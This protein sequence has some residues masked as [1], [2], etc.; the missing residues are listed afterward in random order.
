MPDITYPSL[1]DTTE[2][3]ESYLPRALPWDTIP[4]ADYAIDRQ[5]S[6][7]LPQLS[8]RHQERATNDPDFT[9]TLARVELDRGMKEREYLPL[10]ETMR[11]EQ[12]DAFDNTLLELENQRR[13]ARGEEPLAEL[14][15]TDPLLELSAIA[16]EEKDAE[17]D[18]F[19]SETGQILI[20]LL[21]LQQQVAKAS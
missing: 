12:Q 14:E 2:I 13:K 1:L 6:P 3:G 20:D 21:E 7:L 4:P 10:N 5:L 16:D 9:Y 19:L 8:E 18:P 15:E 11:R 17:D